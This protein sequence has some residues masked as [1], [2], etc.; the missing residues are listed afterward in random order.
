LD[1][2]VAPPPLF[3]YSRS[4]VPL[5]TSGLVQQL[6]LADPQLDD[7]APLAA[8][9]G[10][11]LQDALE[12]NDPV[13]LLHDEPVFCHCPLVPQLCGCEPAQVT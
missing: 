9:L 11:V 2:P 10:A 13:A 12:Q 6:S 3:V 4:N 8:Q 1:S 7:P 5:A